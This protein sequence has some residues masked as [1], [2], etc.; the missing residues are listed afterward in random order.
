MLYS[1]VGAAQVAASPANPVMLDYATWFFATQES[2]PGTCAAC[3]TAMT[4]PAAYAEYQKDWAVMQ[5][6]R[7]QGGGAV[8]DKI[9][10]SMAG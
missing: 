7:A 10:A 5:Q 4:T 2:Y 3:L 9:L 8:L 6:I 1:S